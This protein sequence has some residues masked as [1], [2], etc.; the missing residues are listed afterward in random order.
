MRKRER[1]RERCEKKGPQ[2]TWRVIDGGQPVLDAAVQRQ[3]GLEL[4]S[5]GGRLCLGIVPLG[6]GFTLLARE[7]KHSLHML[8][9]D[10]K[11][12][13]SLNEKK[14]EKRRKMARPLELLK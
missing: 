10:D 8:R 2:K 14:K 6:T 13:A 9:D 4:M 12:I 5:L 3:G 11:G 1:G 7:D